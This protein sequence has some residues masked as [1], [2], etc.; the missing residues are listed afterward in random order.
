MRGGADVGALGREMR[1]G[2][3]EWRQAMWG[4]GP[5]Q[6]LAWGGVGKAVGRSPGRCRGGAAG[7]RLWWGP[8]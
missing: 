6:G 4:R 7:T 8:H 3:R 2:E 5:V 1:A